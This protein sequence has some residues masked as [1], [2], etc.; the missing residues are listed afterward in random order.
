VHS[1][2]VFDASGEV[3]CYLFSKR[4]EGE[5]ENEDWR[6]ILAVVA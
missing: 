1:L 3:A 2:E 6:K 4:H 5:T